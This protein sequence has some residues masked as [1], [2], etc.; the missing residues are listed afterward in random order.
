MRILIRILPVVVFIWFICHFF[1]SLGKRKASQDYNQKSR[2]RRRA[3]K[4]VESS[5]V[6]KENDADDNRR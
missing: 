1:Y 4:V 6:E 2:N 5:V 3:S